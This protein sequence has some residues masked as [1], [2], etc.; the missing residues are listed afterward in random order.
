MIESHFYI[1]QIAYLLENV[2]VVGVE[3]GCYIVPVTPENCHLRSYS[4]LHN[5]PYLLRNS[6]LLEAWNMLKKVHRRAH[7][8]DGFAKVLLDLDKKLHGK[9][10]MEW[11]HK[12]P[13]I[14]VCPIC[15]KNAGLSSISLKLHL[16][17]AHKKISFGSV[18]SA[19]TL[20]IQK[21]L[22]AIK[23]GRGGGDSPTQKSLSHI[24]GF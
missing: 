17:K 9:I 12:R 19:M 10:S 14:K 1:I 20:E 8:N 7:P 24:E 13:A 2:V 5:F 18:D 15:G 4:W 3:G 23:A 16:Q 22:Q 21:A 6:T 11:Q